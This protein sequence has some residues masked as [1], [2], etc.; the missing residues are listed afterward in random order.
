MDIRKMDSVE[1]NGVEVPV[2]MTETPTLTASARFSNGTIRIRVPGRMRHEEKGEVYKKLKHRLAMKLSKLPA[3]RLEAREAV[4]GD[5]QVVKLMGHS[6]TISVAEGKGRRASARVSDGSVKIY[7]AGDNAAGR[8]TNSVNALAAKA[9]CIAAKPL[10]I[11][12][13]AEL[14]SLNYNLR[15]N[16]ISVRNQRT[17]WGSCSR[18]S[19]NISFSLKLM[20]APQEIID[21]VILHELAHLRECN[22][23]RRFWRLL[24]TADPMYKEH[25]R[26]LDKN[27]DDLG[28]VGPEA[29]QC[30]SQ[31]VL[32]DEGAV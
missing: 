23:S 22:H 30:A 10:A 4:F 15:F 27:G 25:K 18:K 3:G 14:N 31:Q 17:K 9:L 8:G 26:W 21:S 6:F 2:I 12:R 13:T 29:G 32:Q 28:I 1:I 16:R 7:L 11:K 20:F 24:E 5:G 19:K